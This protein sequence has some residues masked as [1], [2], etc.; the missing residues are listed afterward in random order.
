MQKYLKG[1]IVGVLLGLMP[2][3]AYVPTG[4]LIRAYRGFEPNYG[5]VQ[6]FEGK[7]VKD[8]IF[9]TKAPGLHLF[10]K[11]DGVS[12]VIYSKTEEELNS[13]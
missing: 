8:I 10:F 4:E 12:Y 2:L 13:F 1:V 7:P 9:S 5:Q 6:D 11:K 3:Y